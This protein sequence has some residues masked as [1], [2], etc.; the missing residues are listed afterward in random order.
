MQSEYATKSRAGQDNDHSL[1]VDHESILGR[2]SAHG[3]RIIF[4]YNLHNLKML[5]TEYCK[6]HYA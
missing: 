2:L 1:L 3:G 4:C 5:N 6:L